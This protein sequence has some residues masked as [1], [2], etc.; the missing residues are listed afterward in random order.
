MR[1]H[2]HFRVSCFSP[3][4]LASEDGASIFPLSFAWVDGHTCKQNIGLNFYFLSEGPLGSIDPVGNTEC[5]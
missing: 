5:T 3:A 4:S 2:W 1:A